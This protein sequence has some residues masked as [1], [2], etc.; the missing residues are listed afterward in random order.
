MMDKLILP[1]AYYVYSDISKQVMLEPQQDFQAAYYFFDRLTVK[2]IF[3]VRAIIS[4]PRKARTTGEKSQNH[5]LNGHVQQIARETGNS[6]DVVKAYIKREAVGQGY[7]FET[8]PSGDIM[9]ISEADTDTSACAIAIDT[10]HRI[11]AEW[12]INLIEEE[13][14]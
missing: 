11:A 3:Q 4:K 8:L 7:P 14:L 6:F 9:P 10:A 12:G 1:N 2:K 13:K 5:H